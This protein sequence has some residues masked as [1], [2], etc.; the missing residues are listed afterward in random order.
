VTHDSLS[1]R[2]TKIVPQHLSYRDEN[3]ATIP[4]TTYQPPTES[5]NSTPGPSSYSPACQT[6]PLSEQGKLGRSVPVEIEYD[7]D[8]DPDIPLPSTEHE[9]SSSSS[10]ENT[11]SVSTHE[12]STQETSHQDVIE[13]QLD[14]LR[15]LRLTSPNVLKTPLQRTTS[16]PS[17]HIS[18]S[19]PGNDR[20]ARSDSLVTGFENL[21]TGSHDTGSEPRAAG[22]RES[23]SPSPSRRR[24]SGSGITREIH[25][26]EDEEPPA[27]MTEVQQTVSDVRDQVTSMARV[28][29][30]S[31][32]HLESGSTIHSLHQKAL[33]LACVQLPSSR[34]VG[35]IGDSGVGKSS[36]INSLLDKV[37]LARAVS[38]CCGF[39][40]AT[41]LTPENRAA[42]VT[43]VHVLSQNTC[44]TTGRIL[45]SKLTISPHRS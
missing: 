26:V 36:L 28:L 40:R 15:N 19:A 5:M 6:P 8:D 17:I 30:S 37:D 21:H 38:D 18:P 16:T 22:L 34:I 10:R 35:L 20:G 31:N 4:T 41:K 12:N 45:L 24:R 43:L 32:S 9:I 14:F 7:S 23:H 3:S 44:F 25:R 1:I 27:H 11:P 33:D 2:V 13:E 42:A 39:P 29:S